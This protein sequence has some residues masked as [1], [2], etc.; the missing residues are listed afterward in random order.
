MVDTA[1]SSPIQIFTASGSF[2]NASMA[3]SIAGGT[4]SK[5]PGNWSL[6]LSFYSSNSHINQRSTLVS[7]RSIYHST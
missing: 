5:S 7:Y 6:K 4:S 3:S 1:L 2:P